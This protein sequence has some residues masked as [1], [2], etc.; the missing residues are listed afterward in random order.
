MQYSSPET[1]SFPTNPHAASDP[2]PQVLRMRAVLQ[3]YMPTLHE[4]A[5]TGGQ[6]P[7]PSV[8]TCKPAD[9]FTGIVK[10]AG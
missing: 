7:N 9:A 3:H 4:V 1:L 8:W 6:P 2:C 5:L 10:S